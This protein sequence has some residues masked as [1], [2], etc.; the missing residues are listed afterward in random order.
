MCDVM[1]GLND[2]THLIITGCGSGGMAVYLHLD[3]IRTL[4][5]SRIS[6]HVFY[7]DFLLCMP[8]F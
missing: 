7:Y 6:I 5:P 8:S 1:I 2:A 4:V 3:Y